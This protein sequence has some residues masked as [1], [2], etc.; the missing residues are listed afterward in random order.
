MLGAVCS[1]PFS[2]YME[3]TANRKISKKTILFRALLIGSILLA[4][5]WPWK[6]EP[7][8]TPIFCPLDKIVH[9]SL[10]GDIAVLSD[11]LGYLVPLLLPGVFLHFAFSKSNILWAALMDLVVGVFLWNPFCGNAFILDAMLMGALG[12]VIGFTA[13]DLF[14]HRQPKWLHIIGLSISLICYVGLAL[15]FILDGGRATGVLTFSTNAP[16]PS[17]HLETETES[18]SSVPCYLAE[19]Q[20][21]YTFA[22]EGTTEKRADLD[23]A[24][25]TELALLALKN[26]NQPKLRELSER[27]LQPVYF[28]EKSETVVISMAP[29]LDGRFVSGAE[30]SVELYYDGTLCSVS[31]NVPFDFEPN[32]SVRIKSA[33]RVVSDVR[34]GKRNYTLF[35]SGDVLQIQKMEIRYFSN[36]DSGYYLPFW[37]AECVN[38]WGEQVVLRIDALR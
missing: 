36:P 9:L 1:A 16:I 19:N 31:S 24:G 2:L 11:L 7:S 32:Q 26:S 4:V 33:E 35:G 8:L 13:V 30:L 21:N 17:L 12:A 15:I 23:E 20:Y 5:L 37:H 27:T 14:S 6:A 25:W 10:Y 18:P 28:R 38:E 3:H 29:I 22:S 34:N